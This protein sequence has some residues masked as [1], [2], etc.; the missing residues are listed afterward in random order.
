MYRI[1]KCEPPSE[2]GGLVTFSYYKS[3]SNPDFKSVEDEGGVNEVE[4]FLKSN[5]SKMPKFTVENGDN[6]IVFCVFDKNSGESLLYYENLSLGFLYGVE[7]TDYSTSSVNAIQKL[8]TYPFPHNSGVIRQSN[9]DI[10]SYMLVNVNS[11]IYD[12]NVSRVV[13]ASP[14][15]FNVIK[16][17]DRKIERNG[18]SGKIIWAWELEFSYHFN[19]PSQRI[20]NSPDNGVVN[21]E[22]F[23]DFGDPHRG[24]TSIRCKPRQSKAI[25]A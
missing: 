19:S 18:Q 20:Q 21:F 17:Y 15:Y 24:A 1:I 11:F 3:E 16:M 6:V 10:E 9:S 5:C 8:L 22:L 14:F 13:C 12:Y 25:Y 23:V 2:S 4:D 7:G